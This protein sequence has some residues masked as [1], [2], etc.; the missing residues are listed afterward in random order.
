[1][2]GWYPDPAGA[3]GR[4][5]YWDGGQWS[6]QTTANPAD[7]APDAPRSYGGRASGGGRVT[8]LIVAIAALVL[9][10]IVGWLVFG[11]Q[12][13]GG[14]FA[15]VPEDT[16]SAAPTVTGWDETSKPTPPPTTEAALV[17]CPITSVNDISDQRNDG[18]MRG[19]GLSFEK[20][21]VIG[22]NDENLYLQW[23]SD[24]NSQVTQ[25][26]PGWMS[27]VGVGQLNAV[28]GFDNPQVAARQSMECFASSGY[29]SGFTHRIDLMDEA[30]T[31]D[32][33][34]AWRLR[35]EVHIESAQMPEIDGDLVDI[36]VVDLGDPERMG[37]FVSSI[38]IGDT[39]RQKLADDVIASLT[40]E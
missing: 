8:W 26:R 3:Q 40:V 34:P 15:D 2:P 22:W 31:V 18:R 25:V 21:R 16:N 14:G 4:Y 6:Q 20:I 10:G 29:Y 23:V 5:R 27:N 1:M 24:F 33:Y 7:P 28:D 35:S 37:I 17:D 38:T 36:I 19:G 9:L 32:G 39:T 12:R 30:T 13:D 11:G